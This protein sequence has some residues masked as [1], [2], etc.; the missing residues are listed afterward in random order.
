MHA[1]QMSAKELNFSRIGR[2]K[3]TFSF[4]IQTDFEFASGRAHIRGPTILD[5]F[6][7]RIKIAQHERADLN[8]MAKCDSEI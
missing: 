8:C 6:V 1:G 5:A 7:I 2:K 3:N 4:E